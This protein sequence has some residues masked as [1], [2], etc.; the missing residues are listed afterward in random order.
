MTTPDQSDKAEPRPRKP[1]TLA[2]VLALIQA[3]TSL[4]IGRRRAL[5]SGLRSFAK[6]VHAPL[7]ELSTRLDALRTRMNR[8]TPAMVGMSEGRWR[9]C[10]S[11]TRKA[12][13]HVG[14]IKAPARSSTPFAPAWA[15]LLAPLNKTHA[16]I[17]VSR[18]A[19]YCTN[20][21][22]A[23]EQVTDADL[24]SFLLVMTEDSLIKK[25]REVH[26]TTIR[27]WNRMAGVQS[28]WPTLQLRAPCYSNT[29]I[30][31]WDRYPASLKQEVDAYFDHLAG[32]D[33]LAELDFR[34][35]K[36]ASLRTRTYQLRAYL[37]ALVHSGIDPQQ[38]GS[39]GDIVALDLVRVGLRFFLDRSEK[40]STKQ[41]HAIAG[42]LLSLA[43]HWVRLDDRA[44]DQIRKL[45]ARLKPRQ[46][47][48][49]PK[50]RD[51]L[52]QFD[53]PENVAKLLGLPEQLVAI[54]AKTKHP[55]QSEA[56]L[57]QIALAIEVLLMVP[58]RRSN[59]ARLE[60]DRHLIRSRK[61]I[62]HLSIPEHEVKNGMPIDAMMPKGFS[63]LLEL[64]LKRYR[65]LL[66][67]EPTPYLFPGRGNRSKDQDG[68]GL[69]I[70]DCIKEH[71]GLLVNPHLFRSLAAKLYLTAH[72]GAYGVVR[73]MNGHKSVETTTRYYCGTESA[74]ALARYDEH[75][76]KLRR[77][78]A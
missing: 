55:T 69:Q 41:A 50:N 51:R 46:Q 20:H 19:R 60:I 77:K 42:L 14:I 8:Y 6:A 16:Q 73:L 76:I 44:V 53:D 71:C 43:R 23:P 38:L 25:P 28:G 18:F 72:P 58:I 33:I 27:V 64:Y 78:V 12:L 32:K 37:A 2:A 67:T 13:T 5:A 45:V 52:R 3:D 17:A 1:Q 11:E 63:A 59:L 75:V 61:G 36:P 40:K 26:Q 9:N 31:A 68:F 24:D 66:E 54:A 35:L 4:T 70:S 65:P 39:L 30:L 49:A 10:L 29:Y 56:L 7:E 48:M 15:A 57:V 22:I 34:P 74:A 47:G 62:V 21:G